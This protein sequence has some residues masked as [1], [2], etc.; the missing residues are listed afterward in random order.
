MEQNFGA[1]HLFGQFA[2]FLFEAR[3][4]SGVLIITNEFIFRRP[5]AEVVGF[6]LQYLFSIF[7]IKNVFIFEIR[8]L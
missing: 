1:L 7:F 3:Q 4:S 5:L 2:R 8:A 6:F